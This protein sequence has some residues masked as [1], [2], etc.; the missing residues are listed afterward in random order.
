VC[1]KDQGKKSQG[2]S[3]QKGGK[4]AIQDPL[5]KSE[6]GATSGHKGNGTAGTEWRSL[7][8]C[9]PE[10]SRMQSGQ[11][12][13][14]LAG[15][16]VWKRHEKKKGESKGARSELRRFIKTG[17]QQQRG[18]GTRLRRKVSHPSTKGKG[19]RENGSADGGS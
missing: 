13:R 8:K 2:G 1:K 3:Q 9:G 10:Y 6:K 11:R 19:R 4:G 18:L 15:K 17:I 7:L 14:R 12:K 16:H 5:V